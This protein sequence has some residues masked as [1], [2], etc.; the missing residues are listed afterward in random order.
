VRG[1]GSLA[2][3]CDAEVD[4]SGA[5]DAT[6]QGIRTAAP[7]PKK[8]ASAPTRPIPEAFIANG[9]PF[10][11]ATSYYPTKES[12]GKPREFCSPTSI[13]LQPAHSGRSGAC[14]GT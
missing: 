8:T 10:P 4:E 2:A 9:P 3:D 14:S 5:A 1:V 11:E 12:V 6:A 13:A 7:T